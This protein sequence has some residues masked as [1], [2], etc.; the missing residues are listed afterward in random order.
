MIKFYKKNKNV[1]ILN[2]MLEI[3]IP[4]L[5]LKNQN[6]LKFIKHYMIKKN[7]SSNIFLLIL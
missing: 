1:T 3:I 2:N 7:N 6:L 5:P 4:V